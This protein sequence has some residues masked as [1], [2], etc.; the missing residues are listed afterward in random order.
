M[1]PRFC[2]NTGPDSPT[3]KIRSRGF[4]TSRGP[5]GERPRYAAPL[6]I[7]QDDKGALSS[8]LCLPRARPT[9]RSLHVHLDHHPPVNRSSLRAHSRGTQSHSSPPPSER[10]VRPRE[11]PLDRERD[12]AV[13]RHPCLTAHTESNHIPQIVHVAVLLENR[14]GLDRRFETQAHG[15]YRPPFGSLRRVNP[16]LAA[17]STRSP[18]DSTLFKVSKLGLV[19]LRM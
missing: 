3:L 15:L 1:R 13:L 18:R 17:T 8:L 6:D 19:V 14:K 2:P 16:K 4:P 11:L 7:P 12:R 10:G 5:F 9:P